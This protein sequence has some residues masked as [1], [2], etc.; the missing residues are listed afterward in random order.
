MNRNPVMP[1]L[2]TMVIGIILIVG[3]GG[4]GLSNPPGEAAEGEAQEE[5]APANPEEI[6]KQSCAACHG[7]NLEGGA[8]PNLTQVG[9]KLSADDI[10]GIIQNGKGSMPGGLVTG[11]A[12]DKLAQWLAEKK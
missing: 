11:E 3:L 8:G 1:Y 9:S 10:K 4:Y 6:F 7:Q 2:I 5:A 12:Q